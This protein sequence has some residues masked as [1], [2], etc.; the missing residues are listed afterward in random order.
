LNDPDAFLV[1]LIHVFGRFDAV[2]TYEF[3]EKIESKI[4]VLGVAEIS[5]FCDEFDIVHLSEFFVGSQIFQHRLFAIIDPE[6]SRCRR[7]RDLI[8]GSY[9]HAYHLEIC[10]LII[11]PSS[12]ILD[13][14]THSLQGCEIVF[15]I[16]SGVGK[17]IKLVLEG[18]DEVFMKVDLLHDEVLKMVKT[19]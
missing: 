17:F 12:G 5:S 8:E 18:V 16:H 3:V 11:F 2:G 4:H 13:A 1:D 9:D 15:D 14:V 7:I 6:F 10:D 19:R